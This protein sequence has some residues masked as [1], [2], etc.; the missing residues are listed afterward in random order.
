MTLFKLLLQIARHPRGQLYYGAGP[1]LMSALRKRWIVFTNPRATIEFG[2]GVHVAPGFSVFIPHNGSFIVGPRTEFRRGFRAEI[3]GDAVVSIGADCVFSYYSLIQCSS[4]VDIGSKCAFGQSLAIFDGN[5]RYR[6][7]SQPLQDQG[8]D[9]R[10]IRIEDRAVCLTKV[11]VT[12]DLGERCVI[13][14]HSFVNRP[15]P[16]F[17]MAAGVPAVVKEDLR[18]PA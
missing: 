7:V 1:R 4:R 6:D 18:A 5:H 10:P 11:T 15:I 9:L 14:A 17:T 8:F 3:I 2:E 12:A 16:A 13:G